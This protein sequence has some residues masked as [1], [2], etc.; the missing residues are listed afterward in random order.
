MPTHMLD[1]NMCIFVLT[2]RP[3]ELRDRFDAMAADLC[4]SAVTLAELRYGAEFSSNPAR[5]HHA[6]D[7]FV[8]RLRVL[9]FDAVAADHYGRMRAA[10]RRAGTPCGPLDTQIGA[11]AS[12]LG[13]TV[14]T[15]NRREFERMP[16]VRVE[17]WLPARPM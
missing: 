3:P 6:I 17:D 14:V 1:T 7:A 9:P 4:I 15:N 11:H 2:N 13:L 16:N 12:S 10:L 5:N 8:A